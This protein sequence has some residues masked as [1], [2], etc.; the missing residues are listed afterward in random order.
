MVYSGSMQRVD[1]GEED[2]EKGFCLVDIPQDRS[3]AHFEFRRVRARS[4]VTIRVQA[5]EDDPTGSVL[6]AIARRDIADAIVRV[7]VQLSAGGAGLLKENEIRKALEP[8]HV[9]A[10]ISKE[11]ERAERGRWSGSGAE[12]LTPM[13]ALRRYLQAQNMPE[14][15][16]RRVLEYAEPLVRG[17]E[18]EV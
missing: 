12:G 2:E 17:E 18:A 15:E 7:Y 5:S 1:F 11:I 4:F 3:A 14:D 8:A 9:V 6:R 10:V 16:S 13:Q